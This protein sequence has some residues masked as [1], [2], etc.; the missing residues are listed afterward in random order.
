MFRAVQ[1]NRPAVPDA[2]ASDD[3]P[4]GDAVSGGFG[5]GEAGSADAAEVA[6]RYAAVAARLRARLGPGAPPLPGHDAHLTMAPSHRL[7]RDLLSVV[8]KTARR[9]ATLVL[10]YPDSGGAA[11][12]LLTV[13]P[14]TLREHAG[15]VA[16]PGGRIDE[17]ESDTAAALREAWEEVALDASSVEVIGTLTPLYVPPTRFA[18]VPVVALAAA[19]PALV[20]SPDEVAHLLP[21]TLADLFARAN[22]LVGTWE[23]VHGLSAVPHHIAR[24]ATG[25]PHRVWG[26]T[27]MMLAELRAVAAP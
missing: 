15:Q 22:R 10:V 14:P 21:V 13:R 26:A 12:V 5:T 27:A 23:T 8:G 7:D 19:A 20:P 2:A 1:P 24:D 11:T 25:A 17:G 3:A 4:P 9:A 6:W 16:F 18:V